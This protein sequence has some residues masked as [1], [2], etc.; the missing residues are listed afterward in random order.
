MGGVNKG[1]M[2]NG[3]TYG[4]RGRC[5][6]WCSGLNSLYLLSGNSSSGL[7]GRHYMR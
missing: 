5:S 2:T 1:M 4:S 3:D 7:S 6:L